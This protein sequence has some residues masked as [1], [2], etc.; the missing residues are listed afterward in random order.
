MI[1]SE[2]DLRAARPIFSTPAAESRCSSA[3][4]RCGARD[5]VIAVADASGRMRESAA[6]QSGAP[7]RTPVGHR[8]DRF[9]R[10]ARVERHDGR[11]RHAADGRDQL[12]YAQFLP[13]EGKARGV[14]IDVNG[15]A[16]RH[17]FPD[18]KSTFRATARSTLRALCRCLDRKTDTA[19]R[20]ELP[21]IAQTMAEDHDEPRTGRRTTPINP[22]LSFAN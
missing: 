7:R 15:R 3:P 22:E 14:Q 4:A 19:W 16:A 6:R 2:N 8:H 13:R 1:P 20:D 17:T 5:E 18:A 9:A 10:H 21:R 12:S 11:L